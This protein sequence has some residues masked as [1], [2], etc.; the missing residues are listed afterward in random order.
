MPEPF[1]QQSGM[2]FTE[3]EKPHRQVLKP[4]DK[5][6]TGTLIYYPEV[7]ISSGKPDRGIQHDFYKIT[8]GQKKARL[9]KTFH[10]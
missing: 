7:M 8:G 6:I 2:G 5:Q 10:I 4:T 3:Q 9:C 1:P